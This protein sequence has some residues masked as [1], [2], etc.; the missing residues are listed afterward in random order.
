MAIDFTTEFG[1]HVLDR[2]ENEQVIWLTVITP[3]GKPAPNPVWF[4]W[5]EGKVLMLSEPHVAKVRAMLANPQVAL[6]FDC[7]PHGN[8]VVVLNGIADATEKPIS[9]EQAAAYMIKYADGIASIDLTPE[10]MAAKYSRAVEIT[11]TSLRGFVE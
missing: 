1:Q 7:G 11:L 8:D 2:L 5:H 10:S 6:S 3:S 4:L 9:L